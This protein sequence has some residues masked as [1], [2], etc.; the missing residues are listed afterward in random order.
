MEPAYKDKPHC[1][2]GYPLNVL[3]FSDDDKIIIQNE[4]LK[5]MLQHPKVKFRKIVPFSII[6]A[7]RKGKSFL[8]DYCLRYLYA[9]YSSI[10]CPNLI[11]PDNWMGAKD[12]PLRGF[13][14]RSGATR[15][16]TGIIV[17]SDVFLHN[18]EMTGEKIAIIVMDTQGLFDTLTTATG[19]SRIFALG[20]LISSIQVLNLSGVV[21]EDQ[22]QY[23]QFATEFA[24]F[25]AADKNQLNAKP[26]QNLMF[27][28]RDWVN[29]K[30][31][32]YGLEGGSTYLNTF[33]EIKPHQKDELKSVRQ[34]IKESFEE[35]TCSLLP[36]PG[37]RVI[38]NKKNQ[39]MYDG[40]WGEMDEE[41]V[42]EL[43]IL[44]D[45]LLKPERLVLKKV[46]QNKLQA[47]EYFGYLDEYFHLFQSEEIPEAKT[48][49]EI[50][51][52][53]N[54][55]T[56]I[57]SC[58]DQY[59][60]NI[61]QNEE[62]IET[63]DQIVIVHRMSKN[64]ALLLYKT[65]KKMGNKNHDL[66]FKDI[67]S[68]KIEEYYKS[69]LNTSETNLKEIEEQK[70]K[71]RK[72]FQEKHEY[73][74]QMIDDEKAALEEMLKEMESENKSIIE[75]EEK[76]YK[77]KIEKEKL[78][79]ES[80][81]KKAIKE[82]EIEMESCKISIEKEKTTTTK[83][84]YEEKH[85]LEQELEI[86]KTNAEVQLAE[87]GRQIDNVK[88]SKD[89]EV[90][91]LRTKEQNNRIAAKEAEQERQDA[92]KKKMQAEIDRDK[93][94]K[95][96][97]E[98]AKKPCNILLYIILNTC[99]NFMNV[100]ISFFKIGDLQTFTQNFLLLQPFLQ[101]TIRMNIL[102][103]WEWQSVVIL[104]IQLMLFQ[105][106]VYVSFQ[107]MVKNTLEMNIMSCVEI[108]FLGRDQ[109]MEQFQIELYGVDI[110]KKMISFM[111]RVQSKII[112]GL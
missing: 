34:F 101:D 57:D 28:V 23:L 13:S 1:M 26:F 111:L 74:L 38:G 31:H 60:Q 106:K 17:W 25:A 110:Q 21:Q 4:E 82:L 43:A 47:A 77:E 37:D 27:L 33:L 8:L 66:K 104:N 93:F 95:L 61:F 65:S 20:T 79:V 100:L 45:H 80:R 9:H 51:V 91:A 73:Q 72:L 84:L 49:Y 6:G 81:I 88:I 7:Y 70:E 96:Y 32:D 69:W 63:S 11:N 35:L 58:Y 97:A 50:T 10:N 68:L 76:L 94:E 36:H 3:K 56:L 92:I 24:K 90:L 39:Q 5:E 53:K 62:L 30:D 15:D 14:W 86:L 107:M 18:C 19:N 105:I 64:D 54:M 78:K 40:N 75:R 16:T 109:Q 108:A 52:D 112:A 29:W 12:E 99:I 98:E 55:N 42:K 41:F 46:N 87:K 48:I 83:K 2:N 89:R 85:R 67:L 44:I 102:Y 103:M 59:V 71:T 22:L